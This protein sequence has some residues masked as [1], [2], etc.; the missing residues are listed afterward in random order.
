MFFTPP[1]LSRICNNQLDKTPDF[2]KSDSKDDD[3]GLNTYCI[4]I[5]KK[6]AQLK[7]LKQVIHIFREC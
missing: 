5:Y 2:L 6:E 4:C 3:G 1:K 7:T